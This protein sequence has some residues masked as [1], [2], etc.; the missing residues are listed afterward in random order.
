MIEDNFL[1]IFKSSIFKT[2]VENEKAKS[3]F[4]DLL[5]GEKNSPNN[6]MHISNKGGFQTRPFTYMYD[7][8]IINDIFI[9]PCRKYFKNLNIYVSATM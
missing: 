9:N 2:K 1:T 7:D 6:S 3:Y 5:E 4:L 8:N